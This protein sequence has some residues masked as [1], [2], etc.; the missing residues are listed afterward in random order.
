[1][2]VQLV[3]CGMK[4]IDLRNEALN[5]LGTYFSNNITIK[6]SNFLKVVSNLKALLKLWQFQ[7]VTLEKRII[8]FKSLL[9][10]AR[11][12]ESTSG[13]LLLQTEYSLYIYFSLNTFST[14]Y[15]RL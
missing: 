13:G 12:H 8:V 3:A 15:V 2:A 7:N 14:L 10:G 5:I 11:F 1:M 9:F 6:E 4:C